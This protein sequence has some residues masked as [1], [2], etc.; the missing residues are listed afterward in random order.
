MPISHVFNSL[1]C[2][3]VFLSLRGWFP[4]CLRR[5]KDSQPMV[6]H[7]SWDCILGVAYYKLEEGIGVIG[8]RL[9]VSLFLFC[10]R[11]IYF[12]WGF[13]HE[14]GKQCLQEGVSALSPSCLVLSPVLR[15][16][17][18]FCWSL[19]PPSVVCAVQEVRKDS[20]QMCLLKRFLAVLCSVKQ[21]IHRAFRHCLKTR[22]I[23]WVSPSAPGKLTAPGRW[24]V[25]SWWRYDH[26]WVV[27]FLPNRGLVWR[28][29]L[30]K[31]LD[32]SFRFGDMFQ[33]AWTL[34]ERF[35]HVLATF[36]NCGS[37]AAS[38][39]LEVCNDLSGNRKSHTRGRTI[40]VASWCKLRYIIHFA[41]ILCRVLCVQ[42]HS[43][44]R[45]FERKFSTCASLEHA[46]KE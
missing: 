46:L 42:V 23:W 2:A 16:L 32:I 28:G 21:T 25:V 24:R 38:P 34:R 11:K 31:W 36:F 45:G 30:L 15:E 29:G 19:C 10:F 37:G 33:Q 14:H 27:G 35:L 7:N 5:N 12:S 1:R 8:F 41:S 39:W 40:C 4:R 43:I 44:L 18:S 20:L 26:K 6:C 9:V 17:F 22:L 13:L 3:Q